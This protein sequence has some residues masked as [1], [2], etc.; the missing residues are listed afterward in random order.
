MV[1]IAVGQL[2]VQR[3]PE[4]NLATIADWAARAAAADARLLVLPEGI[5]A[6]DPADNAYTAE[7]AQDAEGPFVE[8]LRRISAQAGIALAGT[9]HLREP[10]GRVRNVFLLLDR[11]TTLGSYQ[12]LHPYDAFGDRES[13]RVAPG[14][15]LP[16]VVELDGVRLA[17]II[18]YDLRFPDL[19]VALAL[20]GAEVL[21]CPAAWVRG[22]LKEHHWETLVTARALDSTCWVIGA[23]EA[24]ARNIGN[25]LV[26][27]PLGVRVAGAGAEPTLFVTEID[28]ER[29]AEARRRLPVLANRRL[30]A[31]GQPEP[32]P[33]PT[34][35]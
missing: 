2:Q 9:V 21:L 31:P 13:E 25:S 17:P 12:K 26:V 32:S 24:S 4:Q 14:D 6:R 29:V 27:D 18:C 16:E 10:D 7:M 35:R 34:R 15:R 5:I 1:K 8:G 20:A 11:G 28:T 30:P 3:D 33:E 23:G 22:P 19:A